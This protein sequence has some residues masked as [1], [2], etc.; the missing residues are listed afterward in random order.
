MSV[1]RLTRLAT[2]PMRFSSRRTLAISSKSAMHLRAGV[3]V[4]VGGQHRHDDGVGVLGHLRH[5]LRRDRGGRIDH[6]VRGVRRD[7]HLPGAG[8]ADVAL[9]CRDAVDEGLLRLALLQPA[10]ARALGIVIRQ[11]RTVALAREIT[12]EI[13]GY[14]RFTRTTLRIQDENSLHVATKPTQPP[15]AMARV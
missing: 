3:N 7:A 14:R 13:G 2:T 11:Q 1:L 8:H 9:E 10:G 6:H 12:G 5:V 15:V 4:D